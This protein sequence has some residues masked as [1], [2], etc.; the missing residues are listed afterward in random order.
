MR[1][2][3]PIALAIF[4]SLARPGAAQTPLLHDPA[5]AASAATW[6]AAHAAKGELV[7]ALSDCDFAVANQPKNKIALS[8][9]GSV[10][11][12]AKEYQRAVLDFNAAIEV[13]ADDAALYFNRGIAH[14]SM[15][16]RDKANLDYAQAIKLKPDFAA[17]FHNRGVEYERAGDPAAALADFRRALE[18]DANLKPSA[19]GIRRLT[20]GQL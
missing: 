10:W 6:C 16:D 19:D 8:N 9:R 11:L 7:A 15:G 1:S 13:V 14:A 3:F 17:A 5:H 18:I 12:L 2:P 4:I 20:R